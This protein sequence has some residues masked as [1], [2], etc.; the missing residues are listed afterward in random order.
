MRSFVTTFPSGYQ[1]RKSCKDGSG[2]A[3]RTSMRFFHRSSPAPA[4][5]CGNRT[6]SQFQGVI[7]KSRE[8]C[9][10]KP[11]N[12]KSEADNQ[13]SR[14]AEKQRSR[15]VEKQRKQIRGKAKTRK[16]KKQNF[17]WLTQETA[18]L[19]I[20]VASCKHEHCK[21]AESAKNDS[22]ITKKISGATPKRPRIST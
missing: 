17:F 4:A 15:K 2:N 21:E 3:E 22:R 16:S 10:R 9:K 5:S 14:K 18:Q 20:A 1:V 6:V 8:S 7:A 13:R 11:T 19:R 12:E